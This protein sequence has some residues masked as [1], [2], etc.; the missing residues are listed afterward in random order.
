MTAFAVRDL[1][2]ESGVAFGTSGARGLVSAMTDRI[3]HGYTTG[4]LRYLSEIGEFAPGSEVALGGDL[5]QSTPRILRACAQAIHDA[6]GAPVFCGYVPTPALAHYAFARRTPSLMVTGSHIPDDRNGVKFHRATGEVLKADEVGIAR[7]ALALDSSRFTP[8]GR[9]IDAAPLPEVRDIEDGYLQRYLE[10]FGDKALSGLTVGVYQ[11]SA[12]GRDLIG[13]ILGALGA[14]PLP[15]GRSET[16]ISVDTEALRP[17]DI[18]HARRW[19]AERRLDAIVSTDGD[20]D[21]PLLADHRG[22]WLRGDILGLLCARELDAECVVT[23]VSSNTA[24][25]ESGAFPRTIRSRIGSPYVIAAMEEAARHDGGVVCG[26]EAN[27][28]FLLGSAIAR[29]GRELAALP[30]RDAV[31]PIVAVLAAAKNRS[32]AGLCADLPQR[33]TWSDRL[34]EFPTADSRAILAWLTSGSEAARKARIEARFHLLVGQLTR[35][36]ETDG[37]RMTFENGAVIHLRPSGNAPELRCYTETET[38]ETARSLNV[39]ALKLVRDELVEAAR[40]S[41]SSTA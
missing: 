17:E 22:A 3:C 26:Y 33:V 12:V 5:R 15:L 21:R 38:E 34:K 23:P 2:E 7:Q 24:L 37:L 31:L 20:S 18:E 6:G 10:F 32:V 28:G 40:A 14:K 39:A 16:F 13:R 35:L 36:D 30:T 8:D 27:G 1:M 19:A 11:H 4:F 25:E 9:L 29:D 41:Q